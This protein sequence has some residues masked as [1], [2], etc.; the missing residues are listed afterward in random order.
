MTFSMCDH[1][2]FII[3]FLGFQNPFLY[4]FSNMSPEDP[5]HILLPNTYCS[6]LHFFIKVTS[7]VNASTAASCWGFTNTQDLSSSMQIKASLSISLPIDTHSSVH[8]SV[9]WL[10]IKLAI[11]P[12]PPTAF[13]ENCGQYHG[14]HSGFH[15]TFILTSLKFTTRLN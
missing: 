13:F 3:L 10:K 11:P 5:P 1:A 12:P 15:L 6:N 8:S 4:S 9:A 14:D 7:S 2:A